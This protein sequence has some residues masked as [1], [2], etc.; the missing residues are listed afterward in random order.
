MKKTIINIGIIGENH[1]GKTTILESLSY[2]FIPD[3]KKK[4]SNN[5]NVNDIFFSKKKGENFKID[6]NNSTIESAMQSVFQDLDNDFEIC[7]FEIANISSNDDI[8]QYH[9]DLIKTITDTDII[10]YISDINMTDND[11]QKVTYD[12]IKKTCNKNDKFMICITNKCDDIL[13][14]QEK[15]DIYFSNK[16]SKNKYIYLNSY[17]DE[18]FIPVSSKNIWYLKRY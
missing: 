2:N 9:K 15:N 7:L 3:F 16:D 6:L 13:Y 11:K 5:I 17:Y 14:D 1:S 18:E 8:D 4:K 12:I 10:L